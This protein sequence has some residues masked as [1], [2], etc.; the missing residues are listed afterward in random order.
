MYE[1]ADHRAMV[2]GW[3]EPRSP[4]ALIQ[5]MVP[6]DP[7]AVV[8]ASLMCIRTPRRMSHVA[9]WRLLALYHDAD[10][11]MHADPM[12]VESVIHEAGLS[13]DRSVVLTG[14]SAHWMAGS[15]PPALPGCGPYVNEAFTIFTRGFVG[16]TPKDKELRRYCEWA[17][18]VGADELGIR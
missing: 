12:H 8:V 16:F 1:F 18:E 7:W 15:R 17:V 9:T 14:M 11:M 3:R 6:P 10:A 13:R 4:F 2:S 5:E